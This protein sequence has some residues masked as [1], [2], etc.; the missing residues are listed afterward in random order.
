[1]SHFR[2]RRIFVLFALLAAWK[3]V[4]C[5]TVLGTPDIFLAEGGPD[6]TDASP[7]DSSENDPT[8]CGQR[9]H[10][11]LG[12]VCEHGMCQPITLRANISPF[13]IG[14][15]ESHIFWTE[16]STRQVV[17]TDKAGTGFL[18]LA[19]FGPLQAPWGLQA[20]DANVYFGVLNG[21]LARCSVNGC[22]DRP[23]AV[24]STIRELV[25]LYVDPT[26]IYWIEQNSDKSGARILSIDKNATNS[27]GSA[28]YEAPN[29]TN[30]RHIIG[31]SHFLYATASDGVVR[32]ITK[33]TSSVEIVY[34]GAPSSAGIYLD[35][36]NLYVTE[37]EDPGA[38]RRISKK[39]VR[40]TANV[41][42]G[43]QHN[44][45]AVAV[46]GTRIYWLD[47]HIGVGGNDGSL[48]RASTRLP[49]IQNRVLSST[50]K[51]RRSATSPITF[52]GAFPHPPTRQRNIECEDILVKYTLSLSTTRL[53]GAR[54]PP[55]LR[56]TSPVRSL[57]I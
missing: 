12:G 18:V 8:N 26:N 32:R 13:F 10:R 5:S 23:T 17:R 27:T 14:L 11:C 28:I 57:L 51:S 49:V 29:G 2:E 7:L 31:D 37:K 53:I 21:P 22:G 19:E 45:V 41:I 44:P 15:D 4:A 35:E 30:L 46:D 52:A 6:Q 50:N 48:W 43:S 38:I 55:K 16:A 9:G 3:A 1:M 34:Q 33:A 20:N 24:A 42:A 40:G 56:S 25:D 47:Q 36:E 39:A 54:W